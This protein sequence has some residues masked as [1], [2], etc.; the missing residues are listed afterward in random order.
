MDYQGSDTEIFK[1]NQNYNAFVIA[2]QSKENF[3]KLLYENDN[4]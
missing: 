4:Q 1:K 2:L 3:L